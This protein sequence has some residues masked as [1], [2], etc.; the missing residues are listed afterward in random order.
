MSRREFIAGFGSVAAW[1]LTAR[2]RPLN[3]IKRIAFIAGPSSPIP[4]EFRQE[5][6][7]LGWVEG[8]D[9]RI[10][11]LLEIDNRAV[12]A[13]A[14]FVISTAPDLIVAVGTE[15]AQIFKELTDTI[16]ILFA[17]VAD[18]IAINLVKSFARPGGN[19]TGFTNLPQSSLAGRW[20][21]LLKD[22][23]PGIDRVMVLHDPANAVFASM[24]QGATPA[25]DV[26][27]HPALATAIADAEREIETLTRD[28]CG[29]MIVV[30][31]ALTAGN[32]ATI[33]SLAARH[34]LPAVYGSDIFDDGLASY[35]AETDEISRNVA[36]YADRILKGAKP[37]DL[38]RCSRLTAGNRATIVSLAAC[39]RPPAV[40]G[41]D[42]FDVYAPRGY[43]GARRDDPPSA[44]HRPKG[45]RG[46]KGA[47]GFQPRSVGRPSEPR[48]RRGYK[49]LVVQPQAAEPDR[50]G[51][52]RVAKAGGTL[53]TLSSWF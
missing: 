7:R 11:E 3:P 23:D 20:L 6:A 46:V 16:P 30:P 38:R 4:P 19:L 12:R 15:Y 32:R 27:I 53:R 36:R 25:L 5:L 29:G 49:G 40:Y 26:M 14:P 24:L 42:I 21:S 2:A 50:P 8:R 34:H 48:V 47:M 35:A 9:V 33:V 1:P 10:E 41:S 22:L 43:A 31:Y 17:F 13:A 28:P 52:S 37:A 18:P 45:A 39:H 51:V 44:C